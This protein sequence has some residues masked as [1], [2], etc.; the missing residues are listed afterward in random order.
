M[1]KNKL[2]LTTALLA[3]VTCF[4]NENLLASAIN[5]Y[6]AVAPSKVTVFITGN[7]IG[8]GFEFSKHMDG[9]Y[10]LTKR[11]NKYGLSNNPLPLPLPS[12]AF[13]TSSYPTI[14]DLKRVISS[15][16]EI[17]IAAS[18]FKGYDDSERLI[19]GKNYPF[20]LFPGGFQP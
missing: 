14:Y 1:I 19:E 13:V 6:E 10:I 15:T 3:T 9:R 8:Q 18:R 20:S 11:T 12:D 5:T 7:G 16:E 2:T 4:T 17:P